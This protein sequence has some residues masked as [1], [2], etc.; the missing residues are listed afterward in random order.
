[1]DLVLCDSLALSVQR[2]SYF[3]GYL[4]KLKIPLL[5]NWAVRETPKRLQFQI[6]KTALY[7]I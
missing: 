3:T 1:M 6:Y 5:L 2:T 7:R 4:F